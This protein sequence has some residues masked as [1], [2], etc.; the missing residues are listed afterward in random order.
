MKADRRPEC[1]PKP[2]LVYARVN[3]A[4]VSDRPASASCSEEIV[5]MADM[6]MNEHKVLS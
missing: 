4:V 3:P 5:G 6:T 2:E 1:I